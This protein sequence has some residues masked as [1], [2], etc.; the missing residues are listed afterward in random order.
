MLASLFF[1]NYLTKTLYWMHKKTRLSLTHQIQ[2]LL[3]GR[4]SLSLTSLGQNRL[5]KAKVR[6]KIK[7]I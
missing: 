4:A 6:H 5:G 2:T 3:S 7:G 1:Q